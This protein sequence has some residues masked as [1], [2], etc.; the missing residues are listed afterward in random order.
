MTPATG[1]VYISKCLTRDPEK[2]DSDA[3]TSILGIFTNSKHAHEAFTRSEWQR[4]AFTKS[5]YKREH[6]CYNGYHL[7]QEVQLDKWDPSGLVFGER[8]VKGK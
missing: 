7:V 2:D 3:V 4:D 8:E 5:L 1:I 6:N